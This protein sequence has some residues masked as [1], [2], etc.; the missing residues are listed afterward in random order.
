M[1]ILTN[2]TGS[3]LRLL[4]ILIGYYVDLDYLTVKH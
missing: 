2:G 3:I 1:T 4:S